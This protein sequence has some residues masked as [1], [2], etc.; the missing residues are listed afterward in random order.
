MNRQDK[1]EHIYR[2]NF[3]KLYEAA[4]RALLDKDDAL[5]CVHDVM[6]RAYAR[7]EDMDDDSS[8]YLAVSL[9]NEIA[10]RIRKMDVARRHSLLIAG[11]PDEVADD[12]CSDSDERSARIEAINFVAG[13]EFSPAVAWVFDAVFRHGRSYAEAAEDLSISQSAVNKH[14]VAALK[15]LRKYLK[16]N[17][18]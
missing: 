1:F 13:R 18:I 17:T 16:P 14:V 15:I 8:G 12:A 9:R 6:V 5:D 7:I 11:D 10:D 3:R 2:N 4:F